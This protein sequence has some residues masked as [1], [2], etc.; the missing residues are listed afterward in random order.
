MSSGSFVAPSSRARP[1]VESHIYKDLLPKSNIYRYQ[2]SGGRPQARRGSPVDA[3]FLPTC[4]R[5]RGCIAL[6]L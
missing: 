6:T 4:L 2:F 3:S 5:F 1:W